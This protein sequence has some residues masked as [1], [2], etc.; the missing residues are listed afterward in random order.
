[1]HMSS[2]R[3]QP[4]R[5][6]TPGPVTLVA[7]AVVAF[8]SAFGVARA[9]GGGEPSGAPASAEP[10]PVALHTASALPAMNAP[11]GPSEAELAAQRAKRERARERRLEKRKAAKEKAAREE[12]QRRRAERRAQRA[13][14]RKAEAEAK[15]Q[16]AAERKRKARE[17]KR[18]QEENAAPQQP[19]Q[20]RPEPPPPTSTT[21]VG[22]PFDDSG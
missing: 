5:P 7:V 19:E 14:E 12:R 17:R 10:R 22:E 1:M 20:T 15:R 21:P 18:Q 13:A 9:A 2:P 6:W 3:R 16:A 8:G 4:G 11:P